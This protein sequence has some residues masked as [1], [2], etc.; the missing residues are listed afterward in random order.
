MTGMNDYGKEAEVG[1]HAYVTIVLHISAY[2]Q[3]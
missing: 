2:N 3:A 1:L